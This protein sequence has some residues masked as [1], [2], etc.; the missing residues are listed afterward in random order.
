MVELMYGMQAVL[1]LR[2]KCAQHFPI[3]CR[4]R[5]GGVLEAGRGGRLLSCM[6]S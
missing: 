5:E 3:S 1:V 4:G 6:R 2:C